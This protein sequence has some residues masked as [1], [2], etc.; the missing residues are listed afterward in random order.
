MPVPSEKEKRM[1]KVFRSVRPKWLFLH[2]EEIDHTKI[3]FTMDCVNERV[4]FGTFDEFIA[5]KIQQHYEL[6]GF[7]TH[8]ETVYNQYRVM[9]WPNSEEDIF[10]YKGYIKKV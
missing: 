3:E 1:R 5:Q 10:P 8:S 9:V 2:D 6:N 4:I 7:L